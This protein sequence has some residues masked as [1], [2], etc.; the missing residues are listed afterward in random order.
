MNR[1][2]RKAQDDCSGEEKSSKRQKVIMWGVENYCPE[3]PE[4]NLL[5]SKNY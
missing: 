2:K 3:Y 5:F 1:K 4:G